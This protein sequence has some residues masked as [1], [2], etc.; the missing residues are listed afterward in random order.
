MVLNLT[1]ARLF[2]FNNT[3]GLLGDGE[4][5]LLD[6]ESLKSM[7][8]GT[9]ADGDESSDE[10]EE[11]DGDGLLMSIW[12]DEDMFGEDGTLF[13]SF[14]HDIIFP[15]LVRNTKIR[16]YVSSLEDDS[17]SVMPQT[18]AIDLLSDTD[19]GFGFVTYLGNYARWE[20]RFKAGDQPLNDKHN[21]GFGLYTSNHG[22]KK[23]QDGMTREGMKL[24]KKVVAL[25][26]KAR[27]GGE[28][29]NLREKFQDMFDAGGHRRLYSSKKQA[30]KKKQED[31]EEFVFEEMPELG[32]FAESVNQGRVPPMASPR[33]S[34]F[35]YDGRFPNDDEEEKEDEDGPL[36][37]VP[38]TGV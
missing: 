19:F 1:V 29:E 28:W 31:G 15:C 25:F 16:E 24:Y 21:K 8:L 9:C 3:S 11:A 5:I 10:D 32:I 6:P 18:K 13:V 20:S 34:S 33:D 14:L 17:P 26:R 4:D 27:E 23:Y 36:F 2:S 37:S 12:E 35:A 38:A 7:F 22:R 30:P